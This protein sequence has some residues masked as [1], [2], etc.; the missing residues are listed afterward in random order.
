M[1]GLNSSELRKTFPDAFRVSE[2]MR[3]AGF[4][5]LFA[6]GCVRDWLLGRVAKDVDIATDA[7]PDEVERLFPRT[8]AIGKAF[9]VIQVVGGEGV[10]EVATFRRD[11]D[12]TDGRHPGR[13]E[14]STP[15]EDALRRD[16]TINGL[17]LDP[18]SGEIIDHVGGL[19]D[20]RAGVVRAIG[21]PAER[22]R[23][24]HLRMLRAA[25]F[26]SV[27][28]F[29]VDPV[30][31]AAVRARAGDLR[32]VSA[33]RVREEFTRLLT[34]S[35]RAGDA[36]ELLH[37]LGLLT[38]ILPEF[39]ALKGCEQP[40]EYHPEGDV[41]THTV[42]MLN[43]LSHP[44]PALALAVLLHDIGKPATRTVEEGRIRFTGHAQ[45]GADIAAEWMTRMKFSNAL[46]DQVVGMVDR[47]MNFM[48][49][50][51]MKKST[52]RRLVGSPYFEEELELHR[53]DCLCSNGITASHTTL[54][55]V[56]ADHEAEAA[57]P[58]PWVTGR[59]LIGMGLTEGPEIGEWK[60]RAYDEQLEGNHPNRE[61]LLS[62]LRDKV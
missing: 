8:H 52:L 34:E 40:P 44:S 7:S 12:Q 47:H 13:I 43:E 2:T 23:E 37:D 48:N 27:L 55:K 45:V 60:H 33:E 51:H 35:P 18:A 4:E 15:E 28:G 58:E 9:G 22:F 16:F 32:K 41:W 24:D 14:P 19:D 3:D 25:R 53:I 29:A 10:Y 39:L 56:R 20:L 59:D 17:F 62:W 30:T 54:L 49:V 11:L 61:A 21:D 50:P 31:A 26:A 42:M 46:R 36:V 1:S 38:H 6:G 5:A 57:L